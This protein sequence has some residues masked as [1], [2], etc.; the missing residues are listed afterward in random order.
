LAI[1][2]YLSPSVDTGSI[3]GRSGECHL[4]LASASER[5]RKMEAE[6]R[7]LAIC[8][9]LSPSV[10]TGSITGRSGECHLALASASE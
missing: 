7:L 3:T 5:L 10:D 8:G 1:C 9:Y 2:G 4:A 6:S